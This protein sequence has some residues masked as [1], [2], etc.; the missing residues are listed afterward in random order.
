MAK[1]KRKV[2]SKETKALKAAKRAAK[3]AAEKKKKQE[4]GRRKC[5]RDKIANEVNVILQ[6]RE[7]DRKR[8]RE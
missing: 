1:R 7:N 2:D 3:R 6:G 4:D 8:S 5:N